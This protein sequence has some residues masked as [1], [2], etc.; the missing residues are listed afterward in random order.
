M[1]WFSTNNRSVGVAL[2]KVSNLFLLDFDFTKHPESKIWYNENKYRL[3]RTWTEKTKSGGLHLYFRWTP[4]LEQKQTNTTSVLHKGV[5]TKGYGG[6]SKITPS[7]GYEW[8]NPPHLTTLANPP[9]WLVDLL[10]VRGSFIKK[11]L[12]NPGIQ[13]SWLEGAFND[14]KEGNRNATF[15]RIAGSLR[16]RGY[17]SGDIFQLLKGKAT[18]VG[19]ELGELETITNSVGRYQKIGRAHV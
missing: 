3:P 16:A 10:S 13:V 7:E 6:Y 17:S 2:G 14:L 11:G 12:T 19:F 1:E 9:E 8:I 5:D 4:A 18:E 15:T